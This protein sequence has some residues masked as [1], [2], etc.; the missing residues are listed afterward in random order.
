MF[1]SMMMY[2]NEFCTNLKANQV[3]TKD[4]IEPQNMTSPCQSVSYLLESCRLIFSVI[5]HSL[6]Q[7]K[8]IPQFSQFH[9]LSLSLCFGTLK[10]T[11][12]P[13][14]HSC[15]F[16]VFYYL[17]LLSSLRFRPSRVSYAHW[18]NRKSGIYR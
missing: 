8:G 7:M 3:E 5:F 18:H 11:S 9:P 15:F 17:L 6:T 2:Y 13:D 1:Q 14:H 4:E 10:V 12:H 16:K